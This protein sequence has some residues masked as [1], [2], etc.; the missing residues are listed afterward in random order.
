ME[1]K[2]TAKWLVGVFVA[3]AL[4]ASAYGRVKIEVEASTPAG[5][6]LD[7]I[8]RGA[9]VN[10]RRDSGMPPGLRGT[11]T[12]ECADGTLASIDIVRSD[13]SPEGEGGG[14]LGCPIR[15]AK[16]DG[17]LVHAVTINLCDT[18]ATV[19]ATADFANVSC[20]GQAAF[21]EGQ[22]D[23]VEADFIVR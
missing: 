10:G 23:V 20:A 19:F 8:V 6:T 11:A 17:G 4:A 1:S 7:I 12:L 22:D 2:S 5:D 15:L 18:P 13:P 3:L 9:T 21:G 14:I 16:R